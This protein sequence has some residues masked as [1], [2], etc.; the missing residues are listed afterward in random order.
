MYKKTSTSNPYPLLVSPPF[1]VL[2]GI[3][4][5]PPLITDPFFIY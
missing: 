5:D 2:A 1:D 3:S 4:Y